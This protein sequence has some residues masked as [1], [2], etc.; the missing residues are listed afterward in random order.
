MAGLSKS[1][2]LLHRQC[3]KRLWLS[4]NRPDLAEKDVAVA[5]RLAAGNTVGEV[6][7]SLHSGGILI[8]ALEPKSAL[9]A[10]TE[11]LAGKRRPIFEA[12]FAFGGV[13]VRPDLLFPTRGGY[14][15]VEVKSSTQ[16][17]DYHLA[18]A[19]IQSCVAKMA[20]LPIKKVEIAHI[21]NT[22]IYPGRDRYEDLFVHVDVSRR[23]GTLEKEVP[24]W[25]R[26]AMETLIGLEPVNAPGDHCTKSF[27]CPFMAYCAPAPGDDGFPPEILPFPNGKVLASK[28]RAMGHNDLRKVPKS[29]ITGAM[30]QR[31]WRVTKSGKPE[32]DPEAGETL[33]AL[34]YP[35]YYLDFETIDFA[36]P[37]WAG[38]RPYRQIPFQWSCHIERKSGVIESKGFLAKDA[39]DPRQA[40]AESL[41][42]A[43]A[44]KGPVFVYNAPFEGGRLKELAE[45]FPDLAPRLDAI[46]N[47]FVD[48]L[49]LTRKHYY[50]RDMRGSWS[51]KAV[52]PTI[53]PELAYDDLDVADGSMAQEA[54]LEILHPETLPARK[55]E[56]REALL[57]YCER[58]TWA[59]VRM[60]HFF[61]RKKTKEAR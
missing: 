9:A 39:G 35:R 15:L 6:A 58:D 16:V 45:E 18:D 34:G 2:I 8:E 53:A 48:L 7:R 21:D 60:D 23:V 38:T 17:K 59:L 27:S 26:A 19:A 14:R 30:H 47:R 24:G 32:L 40:F 3:P 33:E 13:L 49:P 61:S 57:L 28:L 11:A 51:L 29:L 37:I 54:F 20:G 25:V 31:V 56:L 43:L 42:K 12:A 41:I 55:L 22:F 50:H 10:T 4:V 44:V 5:I 52:L 36:V 1:R 46:R